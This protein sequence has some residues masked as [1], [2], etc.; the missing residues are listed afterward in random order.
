MLVAA[1]LAL[2]LLGQG[3]GAQIDTRTVRVSE[4]A[5][6]IRRDKFTGDVTCTL[7]EGRISFHRDTLVF[8]LGARVDT[9][10][11][12]FR[13]DDGP[14]RSAREPR[15]ENE[16]HGFFLDHGPIGNP[17]GGEVALPLSTVRDA[18]RVLIR[19]SPKVQPRA[20]DLSRFA[21]ALA[22]AKAAG[23][24]DGSF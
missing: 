21:E 5:A 10:E 20:F 18:K 9:S 22:A 7:S 2:S 4:W 3:D 24:K 16:T 19:A 11:A 23:C 13:V 12:Y 6:K 14:V 15:L 8:H 1:A 17:S